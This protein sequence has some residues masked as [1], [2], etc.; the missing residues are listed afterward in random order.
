MSNKFRKLIKRNNIV[1]T[2]GDEFP[3]SS[4]MPMAI[5]RVEYKDVLRLMQ[6]LEGLPVGSSF[7]I[8]KEL[9]YAVRKLGRDYFP[10]YKIT[11]WDTGDLNRVFR[12]N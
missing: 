9:D 5:R 11:V 12:I 7:P 4:R 3:V 1:N 8:K 6:V 10:E 2:V